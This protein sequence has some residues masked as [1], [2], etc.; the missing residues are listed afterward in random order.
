M[1]CRKT[2][3]NNDLTKFSFDSSTI[4]QHQDDFRST[5][6]RFRNMVCRKTKQNNDFTKFSFDSSTF[7]QHQDDFR[8]TVLRF[9]NTD[10]R[11][12]K[13]NNDAKPKMCD[14]STFSLSFLEIWKEAKKER[15][16]KHRKY[17]AQQAKS[18][19][20]AFHK[21]PKNN[22][23]AIGVFDVVFSRRRK[24]KDNYQKRRFRLR[25]VEKSGRSEKNQNVL[26]TT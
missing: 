18:D 6:L 13:Q 14:S 17:C 7:L 24:N 10:V 5:V 22:A 20:E 25:G 15:K 12:T 3:Q 21:R 26:W 9:H 2:K 23:S 11:K 8:S 16:K 1:V 4:L 19:F